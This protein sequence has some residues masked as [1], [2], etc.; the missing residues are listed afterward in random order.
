MGTGMGEGD[1]LL[2]SRQEAECDLQF[3]GFCSF[4]CPLR[5]DSRAAVSEIRAANLPVKMVT[6]E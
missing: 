6:G 1:T 4:A 3:S 2:M 5:A